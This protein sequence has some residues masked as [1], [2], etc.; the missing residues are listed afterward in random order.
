M[1]TT[2]SDDKIAMPELQQ[3]TLTGTFFGPRSAKT[4]SKSAYF[5]LPKGAAPDASPRANGE[6]SHAN[7]Q[8][9][10]NTMAQA[11]AVNLHPER[12]ANLT[13]SASPPPLPSSKSSTAL[14]AVAAE[15]KSILPALLKALPQCWEGNLI[16]APTALD[17]HFCPH[18]PPTAVRVLNV[19][20]LDAALALAPPPA[21]PSS[22]TNA[23]RPRAPRPPL[24]LNM[25]NRQHGGGGWL[26]G[27]LAQEE[28]LCYRS[29]LSVT[30][31]RRFYPLPP[32]GVVYAPAVAVVRDALAAG[33]AL[34]DLRRPR[35]LGTVAVVSCAALRDPKVDVRVDG[36][37]VYARR[38]DAE[39]M[40]GKMRAVLRV[41]GR[42][43]HGR[44]VLGAL[45]CGA[46][47]NPRAEVCAMWA[48]VLGEREFRGWWEEVVFA[49]L[50]EGGD[51]EGDG[52]FGLF[53]RGLHGLMV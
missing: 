31:K 27:A 24:V 15:T 17:P 21:A 1:D 34:R 29:S 36:R 49:V 28:A 22:T 51:E 19:D 10:T 48:E 18:R 42:R 26:A 20:A 12:R 33:H 46:F 16:H 14:A 53:Y 40:R 38:A 3:A 9:S 13:R 41:A 37:E 35:D 7:G 45:G 11:S 2:P 23:A 6:E 50:E 47:R 43:G 25:A 4:G 30:L 44:V 39:A 32:A 5:S 52:N 8:P